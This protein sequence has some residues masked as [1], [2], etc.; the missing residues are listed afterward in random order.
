MMEDLLAGQ[1]RLDP[2]DP[3]GTFELFMHAIY[4]G[5]LELVQYF[6]DKGE[7]TDL[8]QADQFG[9]T[10]LMAAAS[11]HHTEVTRLLLKRGAQ[12]NHVSPNGW[13][14]LMAAAEEGAVD[15]VKLLLESGAD[16]NLKGKNTPHTP[17][18]VAAEN[19]H[20]DI[21]T[22]LVTRGADIFSLGDDIH[23]LL[24]AAREGELG[25]V[26]Q[27]IDLKTDLNVTD[28]EGRT[29]IMYATEDGFAEVVEEL[30][31]RGADAGATDSRG[32][33]ALHYAAG[34]GH[35]EVAKVLLK[36]GLDPNQM[37]HE[38]H[39]P[40]VY[41]VDDGHVDV[42]RL[43]VEVG[44]VDLEALRAGGHDLMEIAAKEGHEHVLEYLLDGKSIAVDDEEAVASFLA[45]AR[46]G[47]LNIVRRFVAD[48][49]S[50]DVRDE[51]GHRALDL[52][53]REGKLT[54]VEYLLDQMSSD[55]KLEPA[56]LLAAREGKYS[57]VKLFLEQQIDPQA[58]DRDGYTALALAAREGKQ[59]V[60][61]L[62]RPAAWSKEDL[63]LPLQLAAREGKLATVTY[64]HREGADLNAADEDGD[65]PLSLA[66]REGKYAVAQYLIEQGADVAGSSRGCSPVFLAARERQASLITLLASN[67]A[68]LESTCS[69]RDIDYFDNGRAN[70]NTIAQYENATPLVVALT[71]T[72]MASVSALIRAGA[73]VN[74]RSRKLRF[75]ANRKLDYRDS[76]NLTEASMRKQF[77]LD[78]EADG[79]TPLMEAVET[80]NADFVILLLKNGADRSLATDQGLTALQLAK[81]LKLDTI[82]RALQ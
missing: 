17:L 47:K 14:A 60:V 27:L 4:E 29:A 72:D 28:H 39:A 45:A 77:D 26:R 40:V 56:F 74:A 16:V 8:N 42:I 20:T 44:K 52:A 6:L 75:V 30:I 38:G 51:D 64:L 19:G 2:N 18:T 63:N 34:E 36:A 65:T 80:G 59:E 35:F 1:L 12:V 5:E 24:A 41:A 78:Y 43:F 10:P 68:D 58:T 3:Q 9:F 76:F 57:V 33:T 23:P 31:R 66:V 32:R 62:L 46:E 70:R 69:Y 79:W 13:T 73:N 25:T 81:N 48:G 37:D 50:V 71:E 21:F 55:T 82:V 15:A 53:A 7:I 54:T 11:E 61:E 67:K 49:M 22:L